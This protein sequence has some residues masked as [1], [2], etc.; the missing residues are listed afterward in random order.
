MAGSLP[1]R[2]VVDPSK[3]GR[4][5]EEGD[6]RNRLTIQVSYSVVGPHL[7]YHQGPVIRDFSGS[8]IRVVEVLDL[9]T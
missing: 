9:G 3:P 8:E 1:R 7:H 6:G 2:L 4:P 5:V